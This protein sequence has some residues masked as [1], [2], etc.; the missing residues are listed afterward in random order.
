M[1][2]GQSLII[3]HLFDSTNYT[4][5]KVR[6]RVFL[7]SLNEKVWQAMEIAWVKPEEAPAD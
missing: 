7:Q 1:D 6:M 5:W 2:K 4:Y 3:P